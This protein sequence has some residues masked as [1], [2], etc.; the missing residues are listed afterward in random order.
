MSSKSRDTRSVVT[1]QEEI[2]E[3][4][5]SRGKGRG[6]SGYERWNVLGKRSSIGVAYLV[7]LC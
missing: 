6:G 3:G 5:P 2:D 4:L 7:D 1:E